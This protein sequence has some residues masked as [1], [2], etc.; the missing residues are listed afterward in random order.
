MTMK[1]TIKLTIFCLSLALLCACA[2]KAAEPEAEMRVPIPVPPSVGEKAPQPE[3]VPV[4]GAVAP[5]PS[6]RQEF[7]KK[8]YFAFDR[9]DLSEESVAVLNELAAYLKANPELKLAIEGHC[10][11]RGTNEYNLALGER[12][13]KAA[14]DYL[15][16]LGVDSSRLSTISYGEERPADPGHN[17]EAWAKNRRDEFVFAK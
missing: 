17:E 5:A 16:S 14:L 15:V 6:Q 9:F 3:G 10:D 2:K 1:S 13:A 7:G 4:E 11:E 12:R 8:I